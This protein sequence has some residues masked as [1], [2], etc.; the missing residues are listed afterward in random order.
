MASSGRVVGAGLRVP[1][2][3]LVFNRP[4]TTARVFDAIRHV[5]PRRLFVAADGPR[6]DHAGE[7]DRCAEVRRIA[8]EVDWPCEVRTL[9][10]GENLGC[11][12]AVSGALNWFF[13]CEPEGIVLEDD[14]LPDGTFFRFSEELLARYRDDDRVMAI[15]GNH[16]HGKAHDPGYSY[17]FSRYNHVWGWASWRRAWRHYDDDM[18]IWPE[19]RD[20]DWLAQ[21]GDGHGDFV[22]YW[23]RIFDEVYAG[24]VDSWA[25]RWTFSSW[26]SGGLAALPARNLV[27][28]IGFGAD[29]THTTSAGG[30]RG[31]LPLERLDFPLRHPPQVIRD[32]DADRWTDLK[33]FRT[34]PSP[35]E[36]K[37]RTILGR[38][39]HSVHSGLRRRRAR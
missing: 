19:L 8:T 17:F 33:Y 14:C 6:A 37:A 10:R 39:R 31:R 38:M 4:H 13:E 27:T 7:A 9:L 24:E 5:R 30:R 23:T 12:R 2:L 22:R 11:R 34:R 28:N 3:F 15:S 1:V 25:Y 16:H 35:L 20:T 29:A 26:L 21:V 32:A 36:R 18:V